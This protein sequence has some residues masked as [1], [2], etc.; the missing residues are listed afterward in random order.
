MS[1]LT[2]IATTTHSCIFPISREKL[3]KICLRLAIKLFDMI[4]VRKQNS[5][6]YKILN[7]VV[8]HVRSVKKPLLKSIEWN[9]Q[10]NI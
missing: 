1:S 5:T 10:L 9:M 2:C 6:K 8:K 4:A 7:E 3:S